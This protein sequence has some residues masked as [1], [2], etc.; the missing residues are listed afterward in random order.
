M[1]SRVG[2]S[3]VHYENSEKIPPKLYDFF[4]SSAPREPP[5]RIMKSGLES[6]SHTPGLHGHLLQCE[7]HLCGLLSSL[8]IGS[9]RVVRGD[10]GGG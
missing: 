2:G 10:A 6:Q 7:I 5:H 3:G 4:A 1:G 9:R 8:N